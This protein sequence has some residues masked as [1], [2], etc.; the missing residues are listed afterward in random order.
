MLIGILCNHLIMLVAGACI[1]YIPLKSKLR[2]P[3]WALILIYAAVFIIQSLLLLSSSFIPDYLS[4]LLYLTL[5][6]LPTCLLPFFLTK[7]SFFQNLFLLAVTANFF[8]VT[9]GTGN[10]AE[11][12][13]GG[14]F[15][16]R[17]PYLIS[18]LTKL[19]VA[20]ALVPLTLRMLKEMFALQA[21]GKHSIWRSIWIIPALFAVLCFLS[22]SF[23]SGRESIVSVLFLL[24]RLLVGAGCAAT[25]ALLARSFRQEA[26]KAA[27]A[28]HSRMTE[29]LLQVQREQYAGLSESAAQAKA[30]RHDLRHQFS[31][32]SSYQAR[33][34]MEGLGRYLHQ[35]TDSLPAA[36]EHIWCENYAVNAIASHYLT[37]AQAEGITLDV[38]MSVPAQIGA[39]PDIDLCVIVGNLLEN[40][41]EACRRMA[42]GERFIRVLSRVQKKEYLS[43]MVENSFDGLWREKNGVYFSRKQ[44][45]AAVCSA[46][47]EG[48]GLSSVQAVCDKHDGVL[49]VAVDANNFKTS[50]LISMG[51][52]RAPDDAVV[53]KNTCAEQTVS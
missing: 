34:D 48:V 36:P 16:I 19:I 1:R 23:L 38:R 24:G 39:V 6:G 44:E 13:L 9:I 46:A 12:A 50:V 45:S 14:D 26:E 41:L 43:L 20:A 22:G 42:S 53:P 21:D 2:L 47:R 15:A 30:A 32:L 49:R 17:H 25:C 3:V 4:G 29:Q 31:V 11:L 52:T 33:G 51:A 10:Y 8:L 28:E 40:A 18:N 7:K 27:I 35:L 37:M 5:S